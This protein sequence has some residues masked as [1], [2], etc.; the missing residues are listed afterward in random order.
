MLSKTVRAS[1]G[2]A[3]ACGLV[4][5]GCGH[6]KEAARAKLDQVEQACRNGQPDRARELMLEAVET[7]REFRRA[8][9]RSA[10]GGVDR[11]RINACGLVLS[12]IRRVLRRR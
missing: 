8:F 9:D 7:N 6:E 1:A 2:A 12:D 5:L 4:L 10:A 3:L 11:S